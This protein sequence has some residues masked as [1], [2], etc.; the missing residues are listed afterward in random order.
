MRQVSRS[1]PD[2]GWAWPDGGLDQL[3]KAALLADDAALILAENWLADHDIE[4][5]GFREH[6]LLA[7]IAHRFG[8]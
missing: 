6:R 8:N 2:H 4:T 1:F 3:L 5:A 7:A